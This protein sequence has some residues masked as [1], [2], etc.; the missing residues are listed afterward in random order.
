MT[1]VYDMDE[2]RVK[3]TDAAVQKWISEMCQLAAQGNPMAQDAIAASNEMFPAE[4]P[5][6]YD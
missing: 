3:T 2:Y 4:E 1:N 6:T 5:I